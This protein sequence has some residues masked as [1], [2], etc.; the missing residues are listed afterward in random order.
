M[1][2][3][4]QMFME[5]RRASRGIKDALVGL[6]QNLLQI[7][8]LLKSEL[9]RVDLEIMEIKLKTKREGG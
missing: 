6:H 5:A 7:Q 3:L 8:F 9:E 4:V 2:A 1:I